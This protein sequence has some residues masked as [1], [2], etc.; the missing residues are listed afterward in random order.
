MKT[1]AYDHLDR[2]LVQA[3]QLDGRVPFSRIAEVLGVSDQTVSRRYTRLRTEGVI[4]VLGLTDPAVLG[5]VTW[6]VRVQCTPDAAAKVAQAL[7]RR[8]D[9]AWVSLA[10][11]GTE[12]NCMTR[13]HV[14]QDTDAL[15]LQR[16]P[17]TP[18]VVGVTAQ[19]VIHTFFG[20]PQGL[21][22]KSDSLTEE[23]AE[24][25]RPA[26]PPPGAHGSV[27]L[28]EADRRLLAVLGQDG[29]ADLADLAEASGW[30]QSTVRRRM[31]QLRESG[32]LY[33]DLDYDHHIFGLTTRSLLWLTV[34]PAQLAETGQ[35]LAEHPEVAYACATT[36]ATNLHAV[37]MCKDIQSLYLY[38]TSR[39][40]TLS[41]VR[42]VE[43]API[44]ASVKRAGSLASGLPR[45]GR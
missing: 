11:G 18:S 41:A 40:A 45:T 36:G 25:L 21:S 35:A 9:T 5:E 38:L 31:A 37:V 39:I 30:S 10:S 44:V 8:E 14:D 2:C 33:L 16:L 6:L 19:C 32:A 34:A 24:A 26:L 4:R 15:L 17:R 13:S 12:I 23:Q 22:N 28:D 1:R 7:A 27:V 29:R 43:T 3:L 42:Q 20:G